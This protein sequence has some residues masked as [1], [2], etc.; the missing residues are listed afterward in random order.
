MH[1]TIDIP[2]FIYSLAFEFH[3]QQYLLRIGQIFAL[4]LASQTYESTTKTQDLFFLLAYYY[5]VHFDQVFKP[6]V[7]ETNFVSGYF[8]ITL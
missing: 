3:T 7:F 8:Q 5:A 1:Y 6:N 4:W 2:V